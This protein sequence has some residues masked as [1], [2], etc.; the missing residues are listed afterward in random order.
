MSYSNVF[1]DVAEG[2]AEI[3]INRPQLMNALNLE[4]FQ[5]LKSAFSKVKE[6]D[7]IRIVIMTGSGE[8]AFIAGFDM[9]KNQKYL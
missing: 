6:E 8:K 3:T 1:Y 4:T 9:N 2:I 7:A 5:E